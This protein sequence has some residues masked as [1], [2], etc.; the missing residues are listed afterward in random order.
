[1]MQPA[2]RK[3]LSSQNS[4]LVFVFLVFTGYWLFTLGIAFLPGMMNRFFPRASMGYRAFIKQDWRLFSS[5]AGYNRKVMLVFQDT[6]T[7]AGTDTFQ[8]WEELVALKKKSAPLNNSEDAA[9]HLFFQVVN[10]LERQVDEGK[11]YWYSLY[12]D[13]TDSF[14][15]CRSSADIAS[16]TLRASAFRSILVYGRSVYLRSGRL[17]PRGDCKMI[18]S[19]DFITPLKPRPESWHT[20]FRQYRFYSKIPFCISP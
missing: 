8:L 13:Q 4:L 15:V 2:F 7:G 11:D 5:T 10:D 12:P 20:G 1:M 19:R 3:R 14:Y 9:D 17:L 18:V 6:L 16:D